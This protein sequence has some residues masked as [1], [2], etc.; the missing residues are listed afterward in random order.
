[1]QGAGPLAA[2]GQ[3]FNFFHTDFALQSKFDALVRSAE[4]Y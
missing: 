3:N 4:A 1:M 2:A